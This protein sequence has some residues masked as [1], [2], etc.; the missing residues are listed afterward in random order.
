M[1]SSRRG[2]FAVSAED[3]FPLLR[4]QAEGLN[5]VG[6]GSVKEASKN[7]D[8]VAY[9][10]DCV[11]IAS[12]SGVF[13]P[14]HD[15]PLEWVEVKYPAGRAEWLEVAA[16][17]VHFVADYN[18]LVVTNVWRLIFSKRFNFTPAQIVHF[19]FVFSVCD[20]AQISNVFEIESPE[21]TVLAFKDI[22]ASENVHNAFE[23]KD[24]VISSAIW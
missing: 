13:F 23:L 9:K 3:V 20:I 6:A 14:F 17:N 22:T 12:G 18:G 2:C 10:R 7:N 19:L 15:F 21:G 1:S 4:L 11:F 16:E 8:H 5:A 24:L